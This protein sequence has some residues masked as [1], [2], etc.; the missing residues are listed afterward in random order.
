MKK[1]T[2]ILS[3]VILCSGLTA[4][5]VSGSVT[6]ANNEPLIGVNIQEAGTANGATTD[7]YGSY[8][9]TVQSLNATLIFSYIGFTT[10]EKALN[11]QNILNVTFELISTRH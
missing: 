4:Q 1:L 9:I 11:G 8:Q 3:V 10:V 7:E 5:T 2:L 6:D